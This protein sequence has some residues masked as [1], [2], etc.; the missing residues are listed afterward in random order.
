MLDYK[1][2]RSARKTLAIVITQEAEIEVRAPWDTPLEAIAKLVQTKQDLLGKHLNKQKENLRQKAAFSLNY[3]DF[4]PFLG[5]KRKI[6]GEGRQWISSRGGN[7]Y[8]PENLAPNQIKKAVRQVYK[9]LGRRV[10][11]AKVDYFARLM[12]ITPGGVKVSNAKTRW[13]SCSSQGNL[14][15]SW[16]LL[17]APEQAVDYVVV[18][19]L[20]HLKEPNH[21][22]PFWALVAT[23]CP[24]YQRQQE[25]LKK[26]GKQLARENW[27]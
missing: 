25:Q 23:V 12:K 22:A 17:M 19:E 10:F 14:S 26:L 18:H 1:I 15:F 20:A 3:G 5:Q 2:I 7:F 6:V 21:S 4:V 9:L 8:I 11:F 13:G 16:R 24:D 27:D